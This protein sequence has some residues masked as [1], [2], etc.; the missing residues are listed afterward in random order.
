MAVTYGFYNSLNG[1][2]KYYAEQFSALFD[3][4]ITDGVIM[5]VGKN[6]FTIPG[7][8][9]QVIVQSGRAWFDHTWTLND[10]DMPMDLDPSDSIYGR[11]DAVVLEVD[12]RDETRANRIKIVKGTPSSNPQRPILTD[13]DELH[14]HPLAW[15]TVNANASEITGSDIEIQVGRDPTPFCTSVLQSTNIEALFQKWDSD[16]LKWFN[17]IKAQLDGNIAAN[18]QKQIDELNMW[19]TMII[20]QYSVIDLYVGF[21]NGE[22]A[23]DF[24]IEGLLGPN[25]APM[26]MRTDS[27]GHVSGYVLEGGVTYGVIDGYEDISNNKI[28]EDVT[29]GKWLERE[30]ILDTV[31][32]IEVTS[33]KDLMFSPN[34]KSLDMTLVAGGG[35]GAYSSAPGTSGT[36]STAYAAQVSGGAGGAGGSVQTYD[37]VQVIPDTKY[38]AII[39]AGGTITTATGRAPSGGNT[40][41]IGYSAIGGQGGYRAPSLLNRITFTE[42]EAGPGG[43]NGALPSI[44]WSYSDYRNG[45]NGVAS[46]QTKP[47]VTPKKGYGGSLGYSSKT[48]MAYYSGGGGSGGRYESKQATSAAE[49][50]VGKGGA[51]GGGDGEYFYY[52]R[53]S[54]YDWVSGPDVTSATRINATN[55][56]PNSGSGGGGAGYPYFNNDSTAGSYFSPRP[57]SG[58]S[59]RVNIRLN[60]INS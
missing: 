16:F 30:L 29:P 36:G 32:F 34:V 55:P 54:Q 49:K 22:P 6:L 14:E 60:L 7:D 21:S 38:Q 20:N 53:D 5:G 26:I 59:G 12:A 17:N 51:G 19:I 37:G 31:D 28:T 45:L 46:G 50:A 40:T 25:A 42:A 35:A 10:S 33:T 58:A 2:R 57:S 4:I 13:A 44:D 11:I 9:M 15:V 3:N 23:V 1:D 39:G 52:T 8:R 24:Q 27:S 48:D 18:L 43:G 41:F 56:T 47:A